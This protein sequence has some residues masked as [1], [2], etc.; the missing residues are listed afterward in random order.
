MTTVSLLDEHGNRRTA[1]QK[2]AKGTEKTTRFISETLDFL[3]NGFENSL[4]AYYFNWLNSCLLVVACW[5]PLLNTPRVNLKKA[6]CT[7][8]SLNNSKL[9]SPGNRSVTVQSRDSLNG[10][11]VPS[12][13]AEFWPEAFSA[14]VANPAGTTG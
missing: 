7:A 6:C 4:R 2:V 12:S 5:H 14:F 11:S 1:F 10:N 13:T 9:S 8:S 3:V